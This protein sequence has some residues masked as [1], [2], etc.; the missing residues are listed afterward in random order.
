M[1]INPK[2]LFVLVLSLTVIEVFSQNRIELVLKES[3]KCKLISAL[4]DKGIILTKNKHIFLENEKCIK[5]EKL[6]LEK[7]TNFL[8]IPR[9]PSNSSTN[10]DENDP[11]SSIWDRDNFETPYDGDEIEPLLTHWHTDANSSGFYNVWWDVNNSWDYDPDKAG[12]KSTWSYRGYQLDLKPDNDNYI[13]MS[14]NIKDPLTSFPIFNAKNNW[15][16]YFL[17]QEQDVFDAIGATTLDKLSSIKHKDFYCYKGPAIEAPTGGIVNGYPW[18]CDRH[19]TN[20]NYGD[21]L[22]LQLIGNIADFNMQWQN[23]G[24]VIRDKIRPE[25]EYFQFAETGNYTPIMIELDPASIPLEIGAFINNICIG[26]EAVMPQD[27][28]I[29]LKAYLEGTSPDSIVFQYWYGTKSSN[30]NTIKDYL[31]FNK[32]RGRYEKKALMSNNAF[33]LVRVS[34]GKKNINNKTNINDIV[35]LKI[36]PNPAHDKLNYNFYLQKDG[37]INISI[38]SINGKKISNLQNK[39]FLKGNINAEISL[40]TSWGEEIPKGVYF[41]K[42]TTDNFS[43]TRKLIIK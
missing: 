25:T 2:T 28:V 34:F 36:W 40:K 12:N 26:A 43:M 29:I 22:Q 15:V 33:D 20:V 11:T 42:F 1:K 4:L 17:L 14:G 18:R 37:S 7:G 16:G 30:S 35:N 13:Y 32:Q 3:P 9:L 8:S 5:G 23:P 38:Y 10:W 6:L 39:H 27:S 31:V 21:M 24:S 19:Q 41:I